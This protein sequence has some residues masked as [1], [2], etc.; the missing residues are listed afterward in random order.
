M[1]LGLQGKQALVCGASQGLGFACARALAA[2]GV[3]VFLV[4]RR[5]APLQAAATLLKSEG[6]QVHIISADVTSLEGRVKIR[7]TC[8][9]TDILVTNAGGPAPGDF[10]DWDRDDWIEAID[11]NML[12]PIALIQA[13]VDGMMARG[14]GRIVNIT[15]SSVKSPL[16]SLGLSTG[17]RSGLTG[18]VGGL[19]RNVVARG[20]TI[21]NI[22]PGTFSTARLEGNFLA[23]AQREG[24]PVEEVIQ[25]RLHKHPA[26]RF[27]QPDEL[28]KTCAFLCSVHAGYI[29]GQNILMDGGSFP[30]VL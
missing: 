9:E 28:G 23:Q 30:G 22:L 18:F 6:A 2:E 20:V 16:E 29:N 26:Q 4:A 3:R 19:A 14:F 12:T 25:R 24:R 15:S 17:A 5:E 27:G 10:R 8:A 11:A 7:R 13:Y 21:N 1:D